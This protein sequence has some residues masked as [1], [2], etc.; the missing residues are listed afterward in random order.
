[1]RPALVM[2]TNCPRS[3]SSGIVRPHVEHGLVQPAHELVDD[4]AQ[5]PGVGNLPL[6][7][8]GDDL[9]VG[10]DI[11]LEIAVLGVGRAAARAHGAQ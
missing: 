3:L 9:G 2:R 10:G 6:N 8:L 1:M 5:R 7:A 11:G 4:V